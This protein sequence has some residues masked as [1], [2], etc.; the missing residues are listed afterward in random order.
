[1]INLKKYTHTDSHSKVYF[2][3]FLPRSVRDLK[4]RSTNT[5]Q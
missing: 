1:V 2:N 3:S 5:P 4:I